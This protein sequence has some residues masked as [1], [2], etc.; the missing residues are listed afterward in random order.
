MTLLTANTLVFQQVTAMMTNDFA[1]QDAA[2]AVVGRVET[3]GSLGSLL[4]KGSRHFTVRDADDQAVLGVRDPLNFLRDTFTLENPDGAELGQ[5]RKRF[6]FF[7]QHL[8]ITL[9]SGEVIN[10]QGNLRGMDF[11][12]NTQG[13]LV[14][15]VSRKWSGLAKGLL[16]HSTYAL[17]F[18]ADAPV[19]TRRAVIGAIIVLDLVRNKGKNSSS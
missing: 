16:G 9:N 4:T 10:L 2:G 3:H 14:A 6:T 19:E 13:Q 8:E 7:T 11:E 12:F 1:I 18:E 17:N 5:V 15:R